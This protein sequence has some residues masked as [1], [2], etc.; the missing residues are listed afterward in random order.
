MPCFY[1]A[2]L[3]SCCVMGP[4]CAV[5]EISTDLWITVWWHFEHSSFWNSL[6]ALLAFLQLEYPD[7][8]NESSTLTLFRIPWSLAFLQIVQNISLHKKW[9]FRLRISSVNVTKYAADWAVNYYHITLHLGCCSS[10]RSASGFWEDPI[11]DIRK[12]FIP[13]KKIW[14]RREECLSHVVWKVDLA[15]LWRNWRSCTLRH[16][17]KN[18]VFH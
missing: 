11:P 14:K 12:P 10:P 2:F 7:F 17:T 13:S 16:C 5:F 18:K 1:T 15:T 9:S 8:R 6:S 4:S 3:L